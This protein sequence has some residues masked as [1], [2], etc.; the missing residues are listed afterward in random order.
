MKRLSRQ[1]SGAFGTDKNARNSASARK[2]DGDFSDRKDE[3]EAADEQV[4]AAPVKTE[5]VAAPP[6]EPPAP[7]PA[8]AP[9]LF[10]SE[11]FEVP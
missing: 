7:P 4:A 5:T 8:V 3:P 2:S 6:A 9:P 1:L 10:Q 11:F